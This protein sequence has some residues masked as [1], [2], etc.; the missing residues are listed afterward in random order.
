MNAI[1]RI[2][3]LLLALLLA[4]AGT[5][6]RREEPQDGGG[7]TGP[8]ETTGPAADV[9]QALQLVT[10]G[11]SD[12]T[13]YYPEGCS[14]ELWGAAQRL[15][16]G[17][18]NYTGAVLPCTGDLLAL[19]AEPEP[20]APEILIGKTQ[21]N[22]SVSYVDK[23]RSAGY[24]YGIEGKKIVISFGILPKIELS[25]CLLPKK[26]WKNCFPLPM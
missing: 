10:N 26:K 20:D 18:E 24:G 1:R 12:Y 11:S 21:R 17:F 8:A 2:L 4:L 14:D 3:P 9:A 16:T 6:C 23:L 7:T 19:G 13:I 22:E 5:A 25:P 15:A